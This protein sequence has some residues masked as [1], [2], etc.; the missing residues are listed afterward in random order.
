MEKT[1]KTRLLSEEDYAGFESVYND[2]K[3]RAVE[4]YKFELKPL[5]YK[6]FLD[7]VKKELIKCIVLL[8]DSIPSAFLIYTTSISEAVELNIIHSYQM[9]NIEERAKYI[10]EEFLRETEYDR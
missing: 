2:F 5:E 1:Y 4:E 6:D 8:E 9:E 7:A 10:I 3:D